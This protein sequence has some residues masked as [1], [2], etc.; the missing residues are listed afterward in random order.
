MVETEKINYLR[1]LE[2]KAI[3]SS[4]TP[5]SYN[6]TYMWKAFNGRG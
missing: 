6:E 3:Y 4:L 2:L 1:D 5:Y